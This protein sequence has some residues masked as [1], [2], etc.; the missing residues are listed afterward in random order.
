M[1]GHGHTHSINITVEKLCLNII[2][3]MYMD[4]YHYGLS[5]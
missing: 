4:K 2:L 1:Y 5:V 3:H